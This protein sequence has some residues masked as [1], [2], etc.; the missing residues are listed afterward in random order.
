MSWPSGGHS[1]SGHGGLPGFGPGAPWPMAP[2]LPPSNKTYRQTKHEQDKQ[3]AA[4]KR[5]EERRAMQAEERRRKEWVGPDLFGGV[6]KKGVSPDNLT[7]NSLVL[8]YGN[9]YQTIQFECH[10]LLHL[11]KNSRKLKHSCMALY[12]FL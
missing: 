7:I 10:I 5:K 2:A 11:I 1:K 6:M 12:L 8:A 3:A 9:L 4:N